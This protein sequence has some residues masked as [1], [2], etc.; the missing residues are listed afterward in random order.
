MWQLAFASL[1]LT[2][3][4]WYAEVEVAHAKINLHDARVHVI[5]TEIEQLSTIGKTYALANKGVTGSVSLATANA[6]TWYAAPAG[7][8]LY[9]QT[10]TSY[11][12]INNTGIPDLAALLGSIRKGGIEVG[13]SVGGQL[14]D[15]NGGVIAALPGAVPNGVI[16]EIQ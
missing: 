11:A 13:I 4:M 7:A 5:S 12:Y 16:V 15:G 8:G 10:G 3:T 6:P 2:F 1:L 14:Q 9:V